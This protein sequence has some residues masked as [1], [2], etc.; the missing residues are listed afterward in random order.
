MTSRSDDVLASL[1]L[2]Q[3]MVDVGARPLTSLDYW[4]LIEHVE[5]PSTLLGMD[6]PSLV[7]DLG[8]T[9]TM[10]DRVA[11]LLGAGTAFAVELER[12]EQQGLRAL[13]PFDDAYPERLRRRLGAAAPPVL[14]AAGPT[15]LLREPGV[16]VVGSRNISDEGARVA[17]HI[18]RL[19][20]ERGL[21]VIS[22][23][24]KG[25]DQLAMNG[26][27]DAGGTAV[28]VLADALD[29]RLRQ[30]DVRR[31]ISRE[32]VCLLT[33]YKPSA[34]FSVANAMARNKLIYALARTTL[35]V[36]ADA[37]KGGTWEGAVEALRRQFG[38]VAVWTGA[39]AG[40]GNE[41]LV[42]R[43][44]RAIT[45]LEDLFAEPSPEPPD[46]T[47]QLRLGV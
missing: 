34:G 13:T 44:A 3:R 19:A 26:A 35:V 31:S 22:G 16:A 17:Q 15:S 18:A 39:G 4:K 25:T 41:L 42:S 46:A 11:R 30:A 23:S 24:A 36:A 1:L 37:E 7:S 40:A 27:V 10:A 9:E 21:T 8:I 45:D 5:Q 33:P 32:E 2:T 20:A 43:G 47:E 6:A 28:G 38:A 29:R 14:H 12:L